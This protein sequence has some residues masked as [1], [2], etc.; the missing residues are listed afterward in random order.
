MAT[1]LCFTRS[2]AMF[3]FLR[4][5]QSGRFYETQGIW[6]IQGGRRSFRRLCFGVNFAVT[7]RVW[8][9]ADL[10]NE[11]PPREGRIFLLGAFSGMS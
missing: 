3:D 5:P 8:V 4:R 11:N 1:N 9:A 7:E 10:Q 2:Q 6:D